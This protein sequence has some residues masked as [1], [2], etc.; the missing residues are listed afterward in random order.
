MNTKVKI[1]GIE[2]KNPIIAASGTFGFGREINQLWDVSQLGGISLKGLTVAKRLGN[3]TPRVAETPM[4]MLNSVGLQNCGVDTFIKDELPVV[5]NFDTI[6]IANIAGS[7]LSEYITMAQKLSNSSVDMIE[8]NISCP[9][10]KEGGIAF[11]V[12][13]KSVFEIVS[14]VKKHCKKPLIVKLTPN[15]SNMK[16]NAKAAEDGGADCLSLINTVTGMAVDLKT[17]R[18]ILANNYGGLS[19]PAIKPIA[20]KM[21]NDCYNTVKLPI[22]GMG[23][24]ST[25]NDVMEFLICGATAVQVGTATLSDPFA[26]LRLVE[27]LKKYLTI[28]NINDIVNEIGTLKLN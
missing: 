2:F 27:E 5:R 6:L 22:I 28:N 14:E 25:I 7:I 24:I 18:P 11:G 3:K 20:L 16:D 4:G 17:K 9:N 23:G 1:C 26:C 13:P 19:G 8:L 15:V 12:L 10:V 21:V